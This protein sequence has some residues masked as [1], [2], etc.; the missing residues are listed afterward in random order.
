MGLFLA[1]TLWVRILGS[2]VPP[3]NLRSKPEL[4]TPARYPDRARW[5]VLVLIEIRAV[6]GDKGRHG[7]GGFCIEFNETHN[8]TNACAGNNASIASRT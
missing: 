7:R 3:S 5:L 1:V 2:K 4:C 6:G 8:Y